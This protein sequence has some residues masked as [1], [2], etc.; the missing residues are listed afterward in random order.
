MILINV[1][2]AVTYISWINDDDPV[3]PKFGCIFGSYTTPSCSTTH[4]QQ[5]TAVTFATNNKKVDTTSKLSSL[6]PSLLGTTES[7]ISFKFM[8]YPHVQITDNNRNDN[9]GQSN[10][11]NPLHYMFKTLKYPSPII[12]FNYLQG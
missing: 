4:N 5:F 6:P 2:Y 8:S 7:T 1:I 10:N 11:N 12:K 9:T 3:L